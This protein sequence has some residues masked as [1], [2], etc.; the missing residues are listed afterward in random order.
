[1]MENETIRINFDRG[2]YTNNIYS[3]VLKL[4]KEK[5]SSGNSDPS[6]MKDSPDSLYFLY[7]SQDNL[8]FVGNQ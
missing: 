6:W 8:N 5:P 2:L 4:L 3:K 1:M 7:A